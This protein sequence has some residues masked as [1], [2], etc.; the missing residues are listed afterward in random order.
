[1]RLSAE[2]ALAKAE[3][4]QRRAELARQAHE[5]G[6]DDGLASQHEAMRRRALLWL[7]E[8]RRLSA[9]QPPRLDV[10]GQPL[11]GAPPPG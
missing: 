2:Q 8:A 1:M 4:W 7:S 10:S 5:A 11:D 6:D 3:R 9:G